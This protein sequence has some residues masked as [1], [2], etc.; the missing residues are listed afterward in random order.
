VIFSA[1]L[2]NSPGRRDTGPLVPAGTTPPRGR[3]GDPAG[4]SYFHVPRD[5]W[6]SS[7]GGRAGVADSG[8][9]SSGDR[10]DDPVGSVVPPMSRGAARLTRLPVDL[11]DGQAIVTGG[12]VVLDGA[13]RAV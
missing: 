1:A 9:P 10:G 11:F 7:D 13:T 12:W 6:P 3:H 8:L 4:R 2:N 5:G